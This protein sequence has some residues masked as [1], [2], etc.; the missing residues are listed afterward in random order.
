MSSYGPWFDSERGDRATFD[1]CAGEQLLLI[2]RMQYP[3]CEELGVALQCLMDWGT[4]E[5]PHIP[6]DE[7]DIRMICTALNRAH[8]ENLICQTH[9][10]LTRFDSIRVRSSDQSH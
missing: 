7:A 9:F 5:S 3:Q 2:V 1:I 8:H 6:G 4:D 10:C